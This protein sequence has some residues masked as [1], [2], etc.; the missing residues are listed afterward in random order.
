MIVGNRVI[1]FFATEPPLFPKTKVVNG[2]DKMFQACGLKREHWSTTSPIRTIFHNAFESADLPYFNP[3]SFRKTLVTLGQK[4]CRSP[5]DF[6]AWSQNLGHE[7]VLTTL[8]SYGEVQQSRQGEIIQQ[9]STPRVES[10]TQSAAEKIIQAVK[11][12]MNPQQG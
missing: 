1:C 11:E 2:D 3:H 8:Y 7:Q 5:E 9:L 4:M 10:V 12:Q 6:K